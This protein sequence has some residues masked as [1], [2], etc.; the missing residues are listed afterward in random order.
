MALLTVLKIGRRDAE[1][2]QVNLCQKQGVAVQ[3]HI[4]GP[5]SSKC[6]LLS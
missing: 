3:S 4:P 6:S 1:S 5:R 2:V